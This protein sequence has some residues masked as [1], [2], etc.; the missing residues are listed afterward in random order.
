MILPVGFLAGAKPARTGELQPAKTGEN[1]TG[2][3]K[4]TRLAGVGSKNPA[5][6]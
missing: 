2:A 3:N 6:P 4:D 5:L 1:L